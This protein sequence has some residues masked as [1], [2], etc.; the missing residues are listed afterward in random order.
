MSSK[1]LFTS[2]QILERVNIIHTINNNNKCRD[3]SIKWAADPFIASG[4]SRDVTAM[5]TLTVDITVASIHVVSCE[6]HTNFNGI[7]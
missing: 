5:R 3:A 6:N 4:A 1:L 2:I 7:V